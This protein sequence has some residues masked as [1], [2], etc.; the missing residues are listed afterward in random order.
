[1]YANNTAARRRRIL[2]ASASEPTY[3]D[4]QNP[5]AQESSVSTIPG[6]ETIPREGIPVADDV[7]LGPPESSQWSRTRTTTLA[8]GTI[9]E[10]EPT[11]RIAALRGRLSPNLPD[12]PGWCPVELCVTSR[13]TGEAEVLRIDSSIVSIG[14][15][16]QCDLR[17]M[18]A[19]VSRRHACIQVLEAGVLCFD[20]GGRTGL[21][22]A[23]ERRPVGWITTRHSVEI[24]PFEVRLATPDDA[25]AGANNEQIESA[26]SPVDSAGDE[27]AMDAGALII[28]DSTL[29]MMG[30]EV[31]GTPA[32]EAMREASDAEQR[33]FLPLSS[34]LARL[35]RG[36]ECELSLKDDQ[37]SRVHSSVM[38]STDSVWLVDL[39]GRGGIRVN[40]T[41]ISHA[42]LEPGDKVALGQHRLRFVR[43]RSLSS[44]STD[45]GLASRGPEVA[46]GIHDVDDVPT[47]EITPVP[48]SESGIPE[49]IATN[50]TEAI[51]D[52]QRRMHEQQAL[53]MSVMEEVVASLQQETGEDVRV[54]LERLKTLGD[55][56]WKSQSE[57]LTTLINT[58][59]SQS[60]N[61]PSLKP[62]FRSDYSSEET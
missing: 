2:I 59:A 16:S 21:L 54:K 49:S 33:C 44:G 20:L 12:S 37:I 61:D 15:G 10:D 51:A 31:E 24:G 57:Q 35:G 62:S 29:Q 14:R 25:I 30:F 28:K 47:A 1:M 53:Q 50:M 39:A 45:P 17:L 8:V 18:H 40:G 19:D 13:L 6:D 26:I 43:D 36:P 3:S 48:G 52:V 34:P 11:R 58:C 32:G 22:W 55:E 38:A 56:I 5:D 42:R 4:E 23:G 46:V 7:P 9:S 27:E 60:G 41:R